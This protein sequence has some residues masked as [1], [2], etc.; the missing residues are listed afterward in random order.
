MAEETGCDVTEV[1]ARH[2]DY[3]LVGQALLL[4]AGVCIEIVECLRQETGH[5]DRVGR[6]QLHVLVQLLIH[7]CRLYQSLAVVEYAIH[8]KGRDVLT[9]GS[10][11]A[12]LNLAHL[13]L[14]I[15]HVNMDSLHAEETIGNGRTS[16]TRCSHE[17]VHFFLTL[18]T[19]KILKQTGHET[20]THILEGE[21]RTMEQL[22][23]VDIWLHLNHWAV[24][25]QS[26][27]NYLFQ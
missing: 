2:T 4:H 12:L 26:I 6:S 10:K 9:Q 20:S 11:L 27:I 18:L 7:E 13:A 15:E 25:R 19:N 16:I 24:E 14:W 23:R 8:L 17:Y 22:Q 5:I 21:S 3:Q 1:T